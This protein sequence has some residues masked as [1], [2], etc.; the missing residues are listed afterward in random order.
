MSYCIYGHIYYTYTYIIHICI[1]TYTEVNNYEIYMSG[2]YESWISHGLYGHI[3]CTYIYIIPAQ[4]WRNRTPN[5]TNF[6]FPGLLV[7]L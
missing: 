1:Y 6:S 7:F 2:M 3:Y 4:E 5:A